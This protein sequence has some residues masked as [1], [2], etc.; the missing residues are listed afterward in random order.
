M[1]LF[2]RRRLELQTNLNYTRMNT[3]FN[4]CAKVVK[5]EGT[6]PATHPLFYQ[7]T[8]YLPLI[9]FNQLPGADY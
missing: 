9:N 4:K 8:P 1:H 3:Y 2:E 7:M 5:A 6:Q